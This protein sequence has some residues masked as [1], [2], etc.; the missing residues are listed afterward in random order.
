MEPRKTFVMSIEFWA[1]A[2]VLDAPQKAVLLQAIMAFNGAD[3]E[4]PEMDQATAGVFGMMEPFFN[5][6][7]AHYDDVCNK[8]RE[9]G[10]KGGL[11]GKAKKAKASKANHHDLDHEHDHDLDHDHKHT[12]LTPQGEKCVSEAPS[13]KTSSPKEENP[14]TREEPQAEEPAQDVKADLS[15]GNPAWKE[16]SYLYS[17]W[18]VQQGR[19]RAWREY[20][21]LKARH[22]VPE[23]YVLAEVIA[24]FKAEDRKWKRGY[25][26]L[27]AT[28]LR[29]RR[30]DDQPDKAPAP[31]YAPDENGR[32]RY[33][34]ESEQNYSTPSE[35]GS[36]FEML[37]EKKNA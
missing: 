32:T 10:R 2:K 9:A 12:P 16:F 33:V 25:T 14:K 23:S 19:E 15:H 20:A 26:P 27:M 36:I 4:M 34:V 37:K 22:L 13:S 28:W 3:C 7:R 29:D 11:S 21:A 1:G 24:R 30:W 6:S 17:L 35:F 8:R 18:P 5:A 31:S